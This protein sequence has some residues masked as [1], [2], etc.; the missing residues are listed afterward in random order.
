MASSN[1]TAMSGCLPLLNTN[2]TFSDWQEGEE[3]PWENITFPD[4]GNENNGQH[5][6]RHIRQIVYGTVMPIILALGIVGNS[7]NILIFSQRMCMRMDVMEKSATS[8]L[9]SLAIAD[10]MFCIIGFPSAFVETRSGPQEDTSSTLVALYYTT[11]RGALLNIFLFMSTWFIIT[12]SLERYFA[13]AH[14]FLA[15]SFIRVRRTVAI[16]VLLVIVSVIINIPD[17]LRYKIKLERC[18][19]GTCICYYAEPSLFFRHTKFAFGYSILWHTLGTFIPLVILTFCNVR[20][21]MEIYRSTS[22]DKHLSPG[23]SGGGCAENR[24][25]TKITFILVAIVTFFLLLVCPSMILSFLKD[26]MTQS[27]INVQYYQIALVI[28][29]LAQA[30]NFSFNF[31]LYCVVSPKFRQQV[32]G[33]ACKKFSSSSRTIISDAFARNTNNNYNGNLHMTCQYELVN[34]NTPCT[35]S[36]N[37]QENDTAISRDSTPC[38]PSPS[39]QVKDTI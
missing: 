21:L 37:K 28:T 35:P 7:I 6:Y 20:L 34:L 26:C 4:F 9:I 14:P 12:L 31:L 30:L 36:P 16:K 10:L 19:I 27:Y 2:W 15:R 13:I 29:N 5:N 3:D 39:N 18:H 11:Y 22:H 24:D 25:P 38:S 8:G 32:T 33:D 17:F 23:P 1:M